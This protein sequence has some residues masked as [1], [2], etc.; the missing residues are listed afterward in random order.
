MLFVFGIKVATNIAK[1]TTI[2]GEPNLNHF[3]TVKGE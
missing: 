1:L 2:G 3:P